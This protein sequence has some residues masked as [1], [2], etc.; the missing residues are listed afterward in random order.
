MRHAMR[1]LMASLLLC[2]LAAPPAGTSTA[3][4][5]RG[6]LPAPT[7][8]RAAPTGEPG[9]WYVG[10]VPPNL[11][12]SGPVLVF[13]HGKGGSAAVWWTETAY[14]GVNDMYAYAYYHGY[15]TAFVDLEPEGDMWVNGH[16]LQQQLMAITS[17]FAVPDVVIIAH[18]K[19]GVDTNAAAAF[20]G[21]GPMIDRVITLGT[22]HWG[23][24]LADLAYSTW[25]W[26]LTVLLG[27][28]TDAS[29]VMQTGYMAWFR[30]VADTPGDPV[31]YY[32]ISGRRCGPFL[33]ALWWGC[34]YL[35][36][37]D[38]GLVPVGASHKPGAPVVADGWWDHDEIRMGS[39]TWG[40]LAPVLTAAGAGN[41]GGG[42]QAGP[43]QPSVLTNILARGGEVVGKAAGQ[44]FP[45][46]SGV[47]KVS[48]TFYASSPDFTA[49][50]T[51]PD[52]SVVR[53]RM[54]EQVPAGDPFAGAWVGSVTMARPEPGE[55]RFETASPH[56]AGYLMVAAIEG[57]FSARMEAGSLLAA[58]GSTQK[59]GVT[60]SQEPESVQVSGV[61]SLN[62]ERFAAF[63]GRQA[64]FTLPGSEGVYNLTVT[65][66]GT[67]AD[68]SSFERTLVG[69]IAVMNRR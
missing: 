1:M 9:S 2:L 59:L 40:T 53:V 66:T 37:E 68:G 6:S 3:V 50:L 7:E 4:L 42:G 47:R 27:Q 49:S 56:R 10:A 16:L 46:E 14:H 31:V 18:S 60:F 11:D 45:V 55:W 32:T 67:L 39:R 13:V 48:F 69:S 58:P 52:G 24:P 65:A 22:P 62:G 8:A 20:F 61:L 36:G 51:G 28:N 17:Y 21:A 26:W 19:G 29:Y 43:V 41:A 34:I 35:S 25:A 44:P 15:R 63:T 30:S 33:S 5:T 54:G 12:P 64:V 23:T 38:D 57:G